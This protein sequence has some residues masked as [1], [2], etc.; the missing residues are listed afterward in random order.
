MQWSSTEVPYK[1]FKSKPTELIRLSRQMASVK[2][3]EHFLSSLQYWLLSIFAANKEWAKRTH[4]NVDRKKNPLDVY[5]RYPVMWLSGL[6]SATYRTVFTRAWT[7]G[8]CG[9]EHFVEACLFSLLAI[10]SWL[11]EINT[12]CQALK[13]R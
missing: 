8:S 6:V 12:I 1:A 7:L 9:K 10:Q 3:F 2:S 4:A 13:L 11:F 5:M